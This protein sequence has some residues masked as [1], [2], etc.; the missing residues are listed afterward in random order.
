[1]IRLALQPAQE[2]IRP[3]RNI[4]IPGLPSLPRP[5]RDAREPGTVALRQRE[6]L[7]ALPEFGGGQAVHHDEPGSTAKRAP[8]A[9]DAAS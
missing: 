7:A 6:R 8:S 4:L 2:H 9:S 5:G 1:M 3:Q